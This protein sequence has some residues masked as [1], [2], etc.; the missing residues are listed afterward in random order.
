MSLDDLNPIL[1]P[2]KRLAALGAVAAGR[3]VEFSVLRELLSLS[4]SDLSKH[5]KVLADSGYLASGRT[6]K[7]AT[8]RTW[9]SI[10]EQGQ[11]ALNAHVESLHQLVD[12]VQLVQ[13][14]RA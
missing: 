14:L 2:P 3:R 6:G 1:V 9:L 10:T 12:P 4:D 5:L 11:H 8:R 7:A 13:R